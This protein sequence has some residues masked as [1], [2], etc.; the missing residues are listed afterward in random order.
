MAGVSANFVTGRPFFFFHKRDAP[1]CL[2]VRAFPAT[3]F[4]R[5]TSTGPHWVPMTATTTFFV[6]WVRF[7]SSA[8]GNW[9][10]PFTQTEADHSRKLV[11]VEAISVSVGARGGPP[12]L[13]GYP[14]VSRRRR[15]CPAAATNHA[16]IPS[17]DENPLS[18]STVW[19]VV[20][21]VWRVTP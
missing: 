3:R 20:A 15:C 12:R 2:C 16:P 6:D 1:T 21:T 14:R 7:C 18:A 17:S 19:G 10:C 4:D 9:K 13:E 8:T 5:D 11:L